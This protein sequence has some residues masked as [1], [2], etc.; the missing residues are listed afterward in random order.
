MKIF[1]LVKTTNCKD[2]SNKENNFSFFLKPETS[3]LKKNTPFFLPDFSKDFRCNIGVIIR[4][5]KLGKH[6]KEKFA[7]TYY[8]EYALCIN[9]LAH[10]LLMEKIGKGLP[11]DKAVSF[12]GSTAIS[13]FIPYNKDL[14]LFPIDFKLNINNKTYILFNSFEMHL[15]FNKAI[16]EISEYYTLKIG[17][18]I[19][20]EVADCNVSLSID[21]IVCGFISDEKIIEFKIK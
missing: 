17:D 18:Y 4:L 6:I 10:D 1:N 2:L 20:I 15:S 21:D 13:N 3:L 14:S 9:I 5:N 7:H 8:Q 19:I 12:D 16:E 11:W